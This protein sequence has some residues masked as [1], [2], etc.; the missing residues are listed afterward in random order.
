M[1]IRTLVRKEEGKAKRGEIVLSPSSSYMDTID[2]LCHL[3]PNTK[4]KGHKMSILLVELDTVGKTLQEVQSAPRV[5]SSGNVSMPLWS[6]VVEHW[7][8]RR[9]WRRPHLSLCTT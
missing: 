1:G 4:G 2:R 9:I 3:T 6:P 8:P 7:D 5:K